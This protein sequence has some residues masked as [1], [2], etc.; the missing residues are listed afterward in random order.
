V[1]IQSKVGKLSEDAKAKIKELSQKDLPLKE[2]RMW[3]N[4]MGRRFEKPAGLKAGLLEKY[5]QCQGNSNKR[6]E[7]LKAFMCDADMSLG[8]T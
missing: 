1:F 8:C 6:W 2:R 4:A 5:Q 3:Y 7:M